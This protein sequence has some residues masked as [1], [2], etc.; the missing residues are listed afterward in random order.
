MMTGCAG[1]G[2]PPTSVALSEDP[3]FPRDAPRGEPWSDDDWSGEPLAWVSEGGDTVTVITFGSSSCPYI[4]VRIVA[5]SATRLAL[6]FEKAPAEFCTEDL[7]AR[8][9]VF[10]LPE[11][12]D[13]AS[14]GLE[15]EVSLLDNAS[16]PSDATVVTVPIWAAGSSLGDGGTSDPVADSIA[17]EIIRGTPA[18]IVLEESDL[19]RGEPLAFWGEGR[20]TI[21]V[22]TWGSSG[23]PPIAR[24][25]E[26][27]GP[28]SAQLDFA[29]NPAEF[30]TADFAPT[31]HVLNAP[32]GVDTGDATLSLTVTIEQKAGAPAEFTVP[33]RD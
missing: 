22:V 17:R 14:A 24:S 26:A 7:A 2:G 12:V 5:L 13:A 29:P 28:G 8:T 23:C 11:G 30:C 20:A 6:D 33:V 19:D 21:R 25:L 16:G 32:D 9:H 4:A 15:G 18:D 27:T 31:T 1:T 10:A 3:G